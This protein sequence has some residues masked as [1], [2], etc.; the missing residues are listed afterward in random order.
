LKP[1]VMVTHAWSGL[2]LHLVVGVC[3]A[4]LGGP[5][6]RGCHARCFYEE[7]TA[8]LLRGRAGCEEIKRKLSEERLLGVVVW[9]CA[10]AV[11]QHASICDGFGP[12]PDEDDLE[13]RKEYDSKRLS[14]VSGQEFPICK[15]GTAKHRK[16]ALSEMN[17]FPNVMR[18][19]SDQNSSFRHFVVV[20]RAVKVIER[21]WCLAEFAESVLWKIPQHIVHISQATLDLGREN[22]GHIDVMTFGGAS[23]ETIGHIREH[24]ERAGGINEVESRVFGQDTSRKCSSRSGAMGA[25][26][27]LRPCQ[28]GVPPR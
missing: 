6:A 8:L 20:D 26:R 19:L 25:S 10:F 7:A 21:A 14:P 15:C 17:K 5:V 18:V 13:A 24:L 12:C 16:G 28:Q 9:I 27:S 1:D 22:F 11:N 2:F 23:E 3:A 4:I